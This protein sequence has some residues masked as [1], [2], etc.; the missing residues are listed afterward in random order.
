MNLKYNRQFKNLLLFSLQI[1]RLC[2]MF[3][4]NST[5]SHKL[6][7]FVLV[8]FVCKRLFNFVFLQHLVQRYY[9]K[10]KKKNSEKKI[11]I[12]LFSIW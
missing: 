9:Y 10:F 5:S 1:F 12:E 7:A 11:G 8:I 2:I 6:D 4:Q 3:H